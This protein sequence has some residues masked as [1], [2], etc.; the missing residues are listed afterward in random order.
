MYLIYNNSALIFLLLT[1]HTTI[2]PPERGQNNLNSA[3]PPRY[4]ELKS[5]HN[6]FQADIKLA[7]LTYINT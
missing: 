1:A 2:S 7:K 6:S 3:Y 4:Y 5:N